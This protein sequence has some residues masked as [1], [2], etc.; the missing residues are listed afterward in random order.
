MV[1]RRKA[2]GVLTVLAAALLA[3][4]GQATP[5]GARHRHQVRL[6]GEDAPTPTPT[7]PLVAEMPRD[8]M[9]VAGWSLTEPTG[10]TG[11]SREEAVEAARA[12]M[13]GALA[14]A[15]RIIA[16][17]GVFTA[18]MPRDCGEAFG[19]KPGE[20][21]LPSDN[22]PDPAEETCKVLFKS[23]PA[24]VVTF[25]GV[26]VPDRGLRPRRGDPAP[27]PSHNREMNIVVDAR[28]GEFLTGLSYR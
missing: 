24:W 3:C 20:E 11:I 5:E 10:P 2:T 15:T 6:G 19:L 18:D 13:P 1:R 17:Y 28:I 26:E 22:P 9:A 7:A 12:T 4:G 8:G 16:R 23:I 14:G 25:Q 21:Y 27:E